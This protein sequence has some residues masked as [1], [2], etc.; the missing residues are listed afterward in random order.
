MIRI[1][2]ESGVLAAMKNGKKGEI[3][4]SRSQGKDVHL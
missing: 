4:N 1:F 3:Y 2:I